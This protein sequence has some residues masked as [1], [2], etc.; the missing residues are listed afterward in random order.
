MATIIEVQDSK[1]EHLTE[2]AEKVAK[3]GKK[4]MECLEE[5]SKEQYG[6]RYGNRS[7]GRY[8]SDRMRREDWEDYPR[9]F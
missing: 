7:K 3:Y 2:Y 1:I 4:M 5:V 6:D 8:G 9:Y